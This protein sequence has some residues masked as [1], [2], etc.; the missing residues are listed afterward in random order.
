M[1]NQQLYNTGYDLNNKHII[2][3]HTVYTTSSDLQD[4]VQARLHNFDLQF[5]QNWLHLFQ[6]SL[7]VSTMLKSVS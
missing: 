2:L 1:I 7:T 5:A 3:L 6:S 4:T